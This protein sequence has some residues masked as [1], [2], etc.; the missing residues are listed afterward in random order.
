MA[1]FFQIVVALAIF[2]IVA[3]AAIY[4]LVWGF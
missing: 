3:E 1:Q 2:A 4:Y